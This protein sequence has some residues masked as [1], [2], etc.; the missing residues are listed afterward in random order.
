M[1]SV[2]C[3]NSNFLS[4]L[5]CFPEGI[6]NNAR[7]TS[8][9]DTLPLNGNH[10]NSYN[11]ARREYLRDCAKIIDRGFNHKESA[12]EKKIL[13]ELTS[14]CIPSYLNNHERS[15]EQSRNLVNKLINNINNLKEDDADLDDATCLATDEILG[16]ELINEE[17]DAPLLPSRA[18]PTDGHQPL[19]FTRRKIPP[20]NSES[21]FP[22]LTN[23]HIEAMQSPNRDFLYTS[24]PTLTG[25]AVTGSITTSTQTDSSPVKPRDA[26]ELYYK[27]MPNLG[28]QN[29]IHQLHTYYP[30]GRGSSDGFIVP[31]SK[32]GTPSDEKPA[33]LVT[34]L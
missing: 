34:S 14:N 13:K 32:D 9:M 30:L 11:I 19:H 8:V 6:L 7:D 1:S 10:V 20:E 21:V 24:M 17:S 25:I 29:N 4:L 27:S 15:C 2:Q 33:H 12:L 26:E 22:L 16:L 23:E 28:T 5:P 3:V 18:Q 31:L